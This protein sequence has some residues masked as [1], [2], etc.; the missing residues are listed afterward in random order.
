MDSEY[1]GYKCEHNNNVRRCKT[2]FARP[3]PPAEGTFMTVVDVIGTNGFPAY[4]LSF[5]DPGAAAVAA[6]SINLTGTVT[7]YAAGGRDPFYRARAPE[8]YTP[9][10]IVS[11][12]Q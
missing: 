6:A 12:A 9:A 11:Y 3:L 10:H 2:C 8:T 7:G 1:R 5:A 4:A